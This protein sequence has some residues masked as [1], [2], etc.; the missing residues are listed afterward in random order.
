VSR[1]ERTLQVNVV[2][3]TQPPTLNLDILATDLLCDASFCE[4]LR[5]EGIHIVC[6]TDGL[7]RNAG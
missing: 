6:D 2:G 1:L 5:L 3:V 4:T 7:G